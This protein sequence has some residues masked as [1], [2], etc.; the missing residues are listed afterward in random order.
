[1][2]NPK[3]SF[4]PKNDKLWKPFAKLLRTIGVSK[5]TAQLVLRKAVRSALSEA[6]PVL[7]VRVANKEARRVALRF[8]A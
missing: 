5:R 6:N 7:P 4:V 1:M 3:S 8:A 2:R